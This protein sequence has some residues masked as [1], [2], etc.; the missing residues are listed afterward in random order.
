MSKFEME[1]R[2]E[3]SELLL[4]RQRDALGGTIFQVEIGRGGER[5]VETSELRQKL[6][7]RFQQ[8]RDVLGGARQA[9]PRTASDCIQTTRL[10]GGDG[11]TCRRPQMARCA[12]GGE[13]VTPAGAKPLRLRAPGKVR[14]RP[15]AGDTGVFI[16]GCLGPSASSPSSASD[17]DD[18]RHPAGGLMVHSS[19]FTSANCAHATPAAPFLHSDAPA[20]AG[21]DGFSPATRRYG[22]GGGG[23]ASSWFPTDLD[24]PFPPGDKRG[25]LSINLSYSKSS[26]AVLTLLANALGWRHCEHNQVPS[27]IYW[28]VAPEEVEEML[29]LRKPNQRVGRFPGMHDLCRKVPFAQI[30]R[31]FETAAPNVFNFHPRSLVL[32][33]DANCAGL[34]RHG[35]AI[36]KP[37]DG[38]Q[39]DGIYLVGSK[40]EAARRMETTKQDSAILQEYISRPLLIDG[41]KFDIRVYVLILSLEPLR[42]FVCK[43]GLVRVCSQPYELPGKQNMH[44]AGMHLTNFS[45]N[46]TNADYVHNDD[47]L[48]G[49][50][51]GKR[52]LSAVLQYL[53]A[54]HAQKNPACNVQ[55]L[56]REVKRV[57]AGG[58]G[59]LC[60]ALLDKVDGTRMVD[61]W[62]YNKSRS[63]K[64]QGCSTRWGDSSWGSWEKECFHVL[65]CDVMFDERGTAY[66][67]EVNANPSMAYDGL[68]TIDTLAVNAENAES[69][70]SP[71]D[72]DEPS[73]P[74]SAPPPQASSSTSRDA[75]RKRHKNA[76]GGG[77]HE[78]GVG[79]EGGKGRMGRA[80]G[81]LQ[82]CGAARNNAKRCV[83][84]N[85]EKGGLEMA[86]KV[87]R[88]SSNVNN[89]FLSK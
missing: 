43:E 19:S 49:A 89:I 5:L 75:E 39:G 55:A 4:R 11:A 85:K 74:P 47:L 71:T 1:R 9:L 32:P 67:L 63:S 41:Y 88:P 68:H 3:S 73:A 21:V 14:E 25:K 52:T 27:S 56:W 20:G 24:S 17:D 16:G 51:G 6:Q 61:L 8:Q 53:A 38:T 7:Q 81:E 18:D 15:G 13:Q 72:T 84:A 26:K 37:D 76:L 45:V 78:G 35:P 59:A 57:V 69:N 82:I 48:Q 34:F 60:A 29:Q 30:M 10:A 58:C 28:A 83:F 70:I 42:L 77:G 54:S 66:L 86:S 36:L 50:R 46:K 79:R 2:S 44:K 80:E 87:C 12:S 65:G 31:H 64:M 62:P 40:E 33:S 22:S 23:A